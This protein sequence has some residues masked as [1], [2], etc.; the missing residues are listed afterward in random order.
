MKTRIAIWANAGAL[1]VAFWA[2]Y[3]M[4]TRQNLLGTGGVGWAMLCLTCPIALAGRHPL[5]IYQ[6]LVANAAT[7][8]LAGVVVETI[9]R[10]FRI[11]S[12][13]H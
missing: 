2:L 1:V 7:Y 8:A 3:I 13:S 10:H 11:R 5:S 12:I 4:L 6:V 9:R